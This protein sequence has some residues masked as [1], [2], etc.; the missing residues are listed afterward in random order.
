MFRTFLGDF[1]LQ[2]L[3][4][5]SLQTLWE[6]KNRVVLEE[7]YI[8]YE[9]IFDMFSTTF[10]TFFYRFL[11]IFRTF[12]GDLPSTFFHLLLPSSTFLLPSTS[13]HLL[14]PSSA[15][16]ERPQGGS[17]RGREDPLG[18]PPSLSAK[19]VLREPREGPENLGRRRVPEVRDTEPN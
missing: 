15:E 12:L 11:P 7:Y 6:W 13:F 8:F 14:P 17:P 10:F 19:K 2:K 4:S 3:P 16:R 5:R 9:P 1:N 18:T